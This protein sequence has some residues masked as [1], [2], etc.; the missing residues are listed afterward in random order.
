MKF[1][2]CA[3][4]YPYDSNVEMKK[5]DEKAKKRKRLSWRSLLKFRK[6]KKVEE[7]EDTEF[8]KNR[9][10]RLIAGRVTMLRNVHL[11][12]A[13]QPVVFL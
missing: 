11:F 9:E 13:N 1:P 5:V 2:S 3:H 12:Y 4:L 7:K 6:V 8:E 10:S